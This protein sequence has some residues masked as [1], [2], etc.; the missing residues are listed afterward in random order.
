MTTKATVTFS[1][2]SNET[3]QCQFHT[4]QISAI[5]Y[6]DALQA[7]ANIQAEVVNLSQGTLRSQS[8][9][10][11]STN[12]DGPNPVDPN[13]QREIKANVTYSDTV[14]GKRYTITIPVFGMDGVV[15]NTDMINLTLG[16]WPQFIAVFE[17]NALSEAGNPVT[18]LKAVMIGANL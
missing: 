3:S 14:T 17:A 10:E 7:I 9:L 18:V 4:I 11:G 6:N 16:G 5:D 1:D 12:Y 15:P 8:V 2:F 13:A